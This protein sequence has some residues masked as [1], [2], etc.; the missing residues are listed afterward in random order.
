MNLPKENYD[1]TVTQ[2]DIFNSAAVTEDEYYW[3]LSISA[4]SDFD[5][6]LKRPIDRCFINNY[7]TIIIIIIH[8]FMRRSQSPRVIFMRALKLRYTP[9]KLL[10]L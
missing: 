9:I 10:R 2:N 6:H 4:D 1:A 5:L 3:A 7:F 8:S